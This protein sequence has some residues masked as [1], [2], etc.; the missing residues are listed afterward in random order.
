MEVDKAVQTVAEHTEGALD[1]IV[2]NVDCTL[3]T[4]EVGA[5]AA[6]AVPDAA[7]KTPLKPPK[8][9]PT[10]P[11]NKAPLKLPRPST[12]SPNEERTTGLK[13]SS[14]GSAELRGLNVCDRVLMY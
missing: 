3:A 6:K 5:D 1:A 8:P 4:T 12:T 9:S 2:R 11:E 10:S 7:G 14:A 13:S